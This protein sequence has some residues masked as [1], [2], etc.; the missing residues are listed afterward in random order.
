MDPRG[1]RVARAGTVPNPAHVSRRAS[2]PFG[3]RSQTLCGFAA[4][5]QP[6][7]GRENA[8]QEGSA[9]GYQCVASAGLGAIPS[10]VL[11]P[12]L[13]PVTAAHLKGDHKIGS[14]YASEEV[15]AVR[16][17]GCLRR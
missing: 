5:H 4:Q 13:P 10:L 16:V 9:R 14:S 7:D 8:G 2:G 15:R 11:G 1:D 6:P 3:L 12:Q 17:P